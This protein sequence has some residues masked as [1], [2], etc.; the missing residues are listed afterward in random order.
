M[1]SRKNLI[2]VLGV[3]S[4]GLAGCEETDA[5]KIGD[6]QFCLDKATAATAQSCLDKI[7]GIE[8]AGANVVRCSAGFMTEGFT[9]AARLIDA[10]DQLES[11]GDGASGLMSLLAF[12]S[13][14]SGAL[15]K[16]FVDEVFGFC[17]KSGQGSLVKLGTLAKAA[18]TLAAISIP[19]L[20]N[21]TPLTANDIKDAIDDLLGGSFSGGDP[22]P[23]ISDIGAAV[24]TT[25]QMGCS[26]PSQAESDMCKEMVEAIN[27]AGVDINDPESVGAKILQ[28]WKDS[29]GS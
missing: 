11:G 6:A 24:V 16:A 10:I 18:T 29:T 14:S 25:Y 26:T 22:A 13:K 7:E 12:R 1:I 4:L 19:T 5:D 21:S 27:D 8:T 15:N 23:I 9:D 17:E 3:L 20:S 2:I 28:L